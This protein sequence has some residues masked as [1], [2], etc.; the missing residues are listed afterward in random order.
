MSN[1]RE[2]SERPDNG[3]WCFVR[4][5]SR[6]GAIGVG[7]GVYRSGDDDFCMVQEADEQQAAEPY[8]SNYGMPVT[9]WQ[10]MEYPKP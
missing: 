8:F 7:I 3:S 1:W 10:P 9:A 4:W 2:G 5:E 6:T